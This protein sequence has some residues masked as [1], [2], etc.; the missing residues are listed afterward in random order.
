MPEKWINNLIF[1]YTFK[2]LLEAGCLC[3]AFWVVRGPEMEMF[4]SGC[5]QE[6]QME[7]QVY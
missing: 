4:A 6:G 5:M 1:Y 2:G 7:E 3:P